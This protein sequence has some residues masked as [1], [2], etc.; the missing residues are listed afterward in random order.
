VFTKPLALVPGNYW[1]GELTGGTEGVAGFRSGGGS[2]V[3]NSND[4]ADGPSSPFGRIQFTG[5][6]ISLY[7]TY[8]VAQATP[9][10]TSTPTTTPS[11]SVVIKADGAGVD[12]V[13]VPAGTVSI[14]V[15]VMTDM[16]ADGVEYTC[17]GCS[18]GNDLS[19]STKTYTPPSSHL[20]VDMLA[21]NS[22]GDGIGNWAGRVQTSSSVVIKAVGSSVDIVSVPPGTA[23]I[24]V[25]VMTDMQADGAE[26]TC[27]GCSLG[28]DLSPTTKV[29][30]PP[31][32]H[33]VVDMLALNSSGNG[34]DSWAGRVQT[35]P[36]STPTPTPTATP[37]PTSTPPPPSGTIIGINDET[38]WGPATGNQPEA[39]LVNAGIKWSRVG[40]TY[41]DTTLDCS[42]C[43]TVAQDNALGVSLT[44]IINTSNTTALSSIAPSAYAQYGLTLIRQN[45]TINLW[46]VGNEMYLKGCGNNNAGSYVCLADSVSYG[47]MYLALYNAVKDAG[48]SNVTLMF[49]A[50]GDY[51]SNLNPNGNPTWSQDANNGG[52]VR[53]AVNKV[54]GLG[55]AIANEAFSIHPYGP[56][57]SFA[58]QD[59]VGTAA[60]VQQEQLAKSIIGSIPPFYI[61]EYGVN[62]WGLSTSDCPGN[63]QGEQAYQVTAAYNVF[64]AD[65]H[66]KGIWLYQTEDDG[67]GAWGV[68]NR[69]GSTRPSFNALV[70]ELDL[71]QNTPSCNPS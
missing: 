17:H 51:N 37:T 31:S 59:E 10:P 46:E 14:H 6:Q 25:A 43:A 11:G 18:L 21:L 57:D 8:M 32:S 20:V 3:A 68:I 27:H 70:Q 52:W 5:E 30:T 45:P 71:K 7:A 40:F 4:F 48:I 38:G 42:G 2:R 28:N 50:W 53:D 44:G 33:P 12:I 60:V 49:N 41:P 64:I 26:Y 29:F 34:F 15:A 23:S 69:D 65:S 56:V 62:Q 35:G 13:S 54:P 39:E 22:S 63:V 16:Q 66:V 55:P 19:P 67:S 36:S 24:H 9:T 1:L 47:K 61:T 58:P